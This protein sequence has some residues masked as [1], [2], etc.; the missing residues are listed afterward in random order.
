MKKMKNI[1]FVLS[2][3]LLSFSGFGQ[4]P[5]NTSKESNMRTVLCKEIT[6]T[7]NYTYLQVSEKDS[8]FW[9]AVPKM[10]AEKNTIY[11]FT[12][13]MEMG[14]F[15]SKEL[16]RTFDQ[17]LFLG[18]LLE[19]PDPNKK[20]E[21]THKAEIKI[22]KENVKIEPCDD[23]ISIKELYTYKEKYANKEV[24][25]KG[26]V[27]KFSDTIMS[28]NWIH[29]QDGTN[30]EINY[31]LTITSDETVSVG[32]IVIIKGILT[33]DKDFGYGYFYKLIIEE[34]KVVK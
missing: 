10:E 4:M 2:I 1:Y 6:Q 12:G 27:T 16:D 33:L 7:T 8:L 28:R 24:I 14:P 11:Y 32:D 13:G 22:T 31:D 30:N 29:L 9:L 15:K 34:G 20:K 25:I 19:N 3:I 26:Q 17:I 5:H 21:G 18:K 23:C